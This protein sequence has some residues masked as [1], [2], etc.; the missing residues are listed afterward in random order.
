MSHFTAASSL[1]MTDFQ[2]PVALHH[3]AVL[4]S[5]VTSTPSWTGLRLISPEPRPHPAE[6]VFSLYP[7]DWDRRVDRLSS[8]CVIASIHSRTATTAKPATTD[9]GRGERCF[10]YG[11]ILE[12][13][14]CHEETTC[15]S[16]VVLDLQQ[17]PLQWCLLLGEGTTIYLHYTVYFNSNSKTHNKNNENCP[18]IS[19]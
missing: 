15:W 8:S 13:W 19:V 10:L 6:W 11:G 12:C 16:S 4:S 14:W 2:I 3:T 18:W 1:W 9:K 5:A 17:Q 7:A